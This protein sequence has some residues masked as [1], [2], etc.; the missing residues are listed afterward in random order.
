[1]ASSILKK[2]RYKLAL[3]SIVIMS[4]L[5]NIFYYAHAQWHPMIMWLESLTTS[6][7]RGRGW[8]IRAK[9]DLPRAGGTIRAI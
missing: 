2:C 5:C 1:M 6:P 3:I 7:C 4:H 9:R 8:D